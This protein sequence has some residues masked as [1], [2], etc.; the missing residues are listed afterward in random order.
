MNP[1]QTNKES[2]EEE[3]RTHQNNCEQ[4]DSYIY[5]Q[6]WLFYNFLFKNQRGQ[7]KIKEDFSAR[8]GS[9]KRGG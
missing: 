9:R 5:S 1:G 2:K 4:E 8:R 6:M 7:F 3:E